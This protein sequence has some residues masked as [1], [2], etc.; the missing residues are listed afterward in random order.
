MALIGGGCRGNGGGG[1]GG[2]QPCLLIPHHV[3]LLAPHARHSTVQVSRCIVPPQS[4]HDVMI[5]PIS[6]SSPQLAHSSV[7]C[8]LLGPYLKPSMLVVIRAMMM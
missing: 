6:R 1:G 8:R 2:M 3:H 5:S 4:W 7:Q